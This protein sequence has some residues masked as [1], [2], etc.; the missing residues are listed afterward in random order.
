MATADALGSAVMIKIHGN[1][2]R[3]AI[4]NF[5]TEIA[6]RPNVV[7]RGPYRYP[8]DLAGIYAGCDLVWAQDL[9]QR[10]GNSDWLLP[11]RLYEASWY[12]CPSIAVAHTETGRRVAS[13]RLGFTIP[14]PNSAE[15]VALLSSLADVEISEVAAD[16]LARDPLCFRLTTEEVRSAIAVATAPRRL[17]SVAPRDVGRT[18]AGRRAQ[19]R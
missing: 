8:Q 17:D 7:Y 5:D 15:L 12:G 18:S 10:G 11:N 16:L 2:H 3:H 9:W 4:P 19:T 6:R 13:D 1:I 14:R